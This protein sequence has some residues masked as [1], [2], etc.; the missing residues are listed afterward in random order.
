MSYLEEDSVLNPLTNRY[1]KVDSNA[2]YNV[3]SQ[4]YIYNREL[5]IFQERPPSPPR[6]IQYCSSCSKEMLKNV[7]L[8]CGDEVCVD[9]FT[10]IKK[11]T[12]MCPYGHTLD[13]DILLEITINQF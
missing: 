1:V 7:V 4:G 3:L 11:E 13:D 2:Y 12:K 8:Y 5:R 10:I 6:E 9:C